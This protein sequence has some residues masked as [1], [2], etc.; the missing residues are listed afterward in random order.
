MAGVGLALLAGAAGLERAYAQ[1]ATT[2]SA[3]VLSF[4]PYGFWPL[5]EL[6]DPA[7]G[8]LT[9][10]D[11]SGNGLDGLYGTAILNA[12]SG[13]EGPR[14]PVYR[15]FAANNAA[16]QGVSPS[17]ESYVRLSKAGW[18][19]T[20]TVTFAMWIHPSGPQVNWTGLLCSRDGP[21]PGGMD[22][23]D[24][25]MLGYIW[26]NDTTWS[27]NSGLIPPLDQ[28]SFVAVAIE[29]TK[30]TLYLNYIDANTGTTNYLSTVNPVA[31]ASENIGTNIWRLATDFY[32]SRDFN[33]FLDAPAVF[34]RTL[35]SADVSAL[36]AAGLG[37]DAVP[38]S[39][40]QAPSSKIVYAGRTARFDVGASG[41]PSPTYQWQVKPSGGTQ[42]TDLA[43]SSNV[44]GAKSASL[45]LLN[46]EASQAGEYRAV[47][48]NLGG[49]AASAPAI[50]TVL[51]VPTL[52][53]YPNAV[54][55]NA[56][57][58]YWRLGED[59][60]QTNAVDFMGDLMGGYLPGALWGP[61]APGGAISGPAGPAF[62]GF[63]AN[64]TAVQTTGDGATPSW[65]SV[66]TVEL[67]TN[68]ATFIA[69]I[70]PAV[71]QQA[72]L[73]GIFMIDANYREPGLCFTTEGQLGYRWNLDTT[74]GFQTGLVPPA[75]EWSMA[76]LVVEP[77]MATVYLGSGGA[78]KSAINPI[79]HVK[80]AAWG[81]GASIG[82]DQG[83]PSRTFDGVIDEVAM[84]DKALSFDQI[85]TLYGLALGKVQSVAPS[86]VQQPVSIV[87]YS[88]LGAS[89]KSVVVGSGP[90]EYQWHKGGVALADGSNVSG[91]KTDTLR[92]NTIA[93]ADAGNYTLVVKNAAGSATSDVAALTVVAPATAY[94]S[95]VLS[96][97]PAAY[98]RLNETADPAS[99]TAAAMDLVGGYNG[100]YGVAGQNG[101][102]AVAGPRPA[103]GFTV[104]ET[105]N[106]ASRSTAD[107]ASSWVTASQPALS[108]DRI[109]FTMWIYPD[110]D[111]ADWAGLL[112]NRS[113]PFGCG[114]GLGGGDTHNMLAYTWNSDTTWS[115]NSGLTPPQNQWSFVAVA[116]EPS[117]AILYL[118][119]TSGMQTATN[120]I[121]H[122]AGDWGGVA[123]FG[124]DGANAGRVFNGIVDEVA[125]FNQTLS[126]QQVQDL[127]AGISAQP[128]PQL[129]ITRAPAG[130]ITIRWDGA[131]TLQSAPTL[132]G[133]ATLWT[134]LGT[135]NPV[136]ITPT[137]TTQFYRVRR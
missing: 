134:D 77:N 112:M 48:S 123:S 14:P 136:N 65:V 131:G 10:V 3:K 109:T 101:F 73:T 17:S 113:G 99:E 114:V 30:A 125:I 1:P 72:D 100:T 97:S 76:A 8:V 92:L 88:G 137:G 43:E 46:I 104:F 24:K 95:A 135:T 32:G 132:Q 36:F 81:L 120:A 12:S 34:R 90:L 33:G 93:A 62:P 80:E 15:G 106:Y 11:A 39:I 52:A 26:N 35:S 20:N 28:W 13:I 115:Y 53:S 18:T 107:T 61:N 83:L 111:Q 45:T 105:A 9:A 96:G 60:G 130:Q 68:A 94:E 7:S 49:S 19:P 4:N 51:T 37:M 44:V 110:G 70:K 25:G 27:F 127:Y 55:T 89:L 63:E 117:R 5:D 66:P 54:Y 82:S 128:A 122:T 121:P 78:L 91:A 71:D 47:A 87:R 119:N 6:D 103:D 31:H 74:G 133:S 98:W 85:N 108:T 42:F 21:R 116:I 56:P 50:L 59:Y 84:F 126:P 102:N 57:V 124:C 64:N 86:F 129:T 23:N 69:W 38:P 58:A 16:I 40:S 2:Y 67:A 29:P 41:T 75:N 79:P 118:A 22:F